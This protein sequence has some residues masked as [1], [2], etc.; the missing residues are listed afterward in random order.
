LATYAVPF[1]RTL[2]VVG[3]L[4]VTGAALEALKPWPLKLLVDFVFPGRPLP[5]ALSGLGD[6][7]GGSAPAGRCAWLA[8]STLLIFAVAWAVQTLQAFVQAGAALRITYSLGA[9]VFEHLQQLSLRYHS[10]QPTG[11]LVR[12]VTQDSR[13][14]RDL[15]LDVLA[16]ALTSLITLGTMFFVMWQLDAWLS[17]VALLIVP[18][19][20]GA[21]RL[22]Y[23]TMVERT[24]DQQQCEGALLSQAERTLTA[25]P[26][27]QAYRREAHEDGQFRRTTER[28]LGAYFRALAAQ[29]KFNGA[30]GGANAAGHAAVLI[31]GGWRVLHGGLSLG[32]LLV[33]YAYVTM[34]YAP[35]DTLAHLAATLAGCEAGARRVFEV[36]DADDRVAEG[37]ERAAGPPAGGWRGHVQFEHISFAYE[38]A[39]SVLQDIEL[40]VRPGERVA[41]VGRTG[42]GKSTLMS[43]L[44]RF[45]DPCSG[46]IRLDGVDLREMPLTTLRAQLAILLQEP[47]L[48]PVSVAENIAYGRPTVSRP[49]IEA[50]AVAANADG[51]IRRLPQGYDTVIGER[52]VTLSGGE[53]QRLAIARALLKNAPVLIL[54]EPT[55]AL[56][57]VT[58]HEVLDAVERLMAGRTTIIIAHRLS[59]VRRADRVIV[60]EQGRIVEAGTPGEL[61]EFGGIYHHFVLLQQGQSEART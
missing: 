7:P 31:L 42:A 24:Y 18:A 21:D 9:R 6:L 58:E 16:P 34:L 60:L 14:A 56:D 57:A 61:T 44:L 35:L 48:L 2:L 49:E 28:T 4:M 23:A 8:A 29:L 5:A 1:W 54:D 52:G 17:L 10:R 45:F 55:S 15:A 37:P 30:V 27:V 50:A 47:F 36:L 11:D 12:R 51:F 38:P 46:R 39:R 43:L 25:L 19:L 3:L 40:E 41:L 13:C 22:F 59:T 32:D 26:M 33:F 53:R 20:V